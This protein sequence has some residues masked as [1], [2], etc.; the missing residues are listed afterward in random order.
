MGFLRALWRLGEVIDYLFLLNY[1]LSGLAQFLNFFPDILT[2]AL[3]VEREYTLTSSTDGGYLTALNEPTSFSFYYFDLADSKIKN[4]LGNERMRCPFGENRSKNRLSWR[5]F[6][7]I[8]SYASSLPHS[9]VRICIIHLKVDISLLNG[10]SEDRT[11]LEISKAWRQLSKLQIFGDEECTRRAKRDEER[12]FFFVFL[13]R[14]LRDLQVRF[15]YFRTL[16]VNLQKSLSSHREGSRKGWTPII[17][18][19]QTKG[20]N[21]KAWSEEDALVKAA[22]KK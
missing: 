18:A 17:D 8:A 12:Y 13:E 20:E 1:S 14:F 7:D 2:T 5:Q 19:M 21:H 10:F 11:V 15:I 4:F 22:Y 3:T 9:S 16:N 6:G